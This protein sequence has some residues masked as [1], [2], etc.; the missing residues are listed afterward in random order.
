[1]HHN[2]IVVCFLFHVL[3]CLKKS[4]QLSSC[5]DLNKNQDIKRKTSVL[6]LY[7]CQQHVH[8]FFTLVR[9]TVDSPDLESP[10]SRVTAF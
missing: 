5:I 10:P 9:F 8:F 6:F 7:V 2:Q 1:M 4:L 3:L